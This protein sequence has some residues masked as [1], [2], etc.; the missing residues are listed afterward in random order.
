MSERVHTI[1]VIR[2]RLATR[3]SP[4]QQMSVIILITG[5][6]GFVASYLLL[7]AGVTR[8]VMRYPLAVGIAYAVFLGCL[9]LWLRRHRLRVARREADAK[10]SSWTD[11][12]DV[13]DVPFSWGSA[14]LDVSEPFG[15]GGGF[16]GAGGGSSWSSAAGDESTPLLARASP[17][18]SVQ[19]SGKEL[20]NFGVDLD[21]GGI[22]LVV[23][24][25]AAAIALSVGLYVVYIAPALFAELLLDTALAA[26]LY[27]R[28]R[29]IEGTHW[30]R[31]AIRRTLAPAL[32]VAAV[33]AMAGMVAQAAYPDAV[34]IGRVIERATAE[35]TERSP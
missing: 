34:S 20:S 21:D 32:F 1:Q 6:V 3:G 35:P 19:K 30:L 24:A 10:R 2:E 28:V 26:G 5:V 15:G 22:V 14:P 16:S 11:V 12:V 8:M 13:V 25:L 23:L 29:A 27:R 9:W 31:S 17:R 4:R 18:P 7:H 33:V